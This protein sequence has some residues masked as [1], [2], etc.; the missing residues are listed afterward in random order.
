MEQIPQ[1]KF[2]YHLDF[3]PLELQVIECILKKG[4]GVMIPS[5]KDLK[6]YSTL[7]DNQMV[8]METRKGSI[9]LKPTLKGDGYFNNKIQ[10]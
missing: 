2:P 10:E 6:Y 1:N 4:L 9:A 5:K 7:I 3:S 8:Y